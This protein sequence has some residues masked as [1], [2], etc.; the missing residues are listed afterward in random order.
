[1]HL[2]ANTQHLQVPSHLV[3]RYLAAVMVIG[4]ALM[5]I[6]A[7]TDLPAEPFILAMVFLPLLGGAVLTAHR[8]GPGGVRQLS[9]GVLRWRIGWRNWALAV[10]VMPLTTLTVA[11][12][13]GTLTAPAEGW[14]TTG[15]DYLV[16]TFLIGTLIINLW[17]ETAWQGLVQRHLTGRFG[18]GYG[19][20]LTAVPFAVIHLPLGFVGG[21][22]L[23]EAVVASILVLVMAPP[24]RYLLGRTD[25]ATGGSLLAVGVLH[26]SFNASGSLDVLVGGW[27]HIVGVAVVAGVALLLDARRT[28]GRR[29]TIDTHLVHVDHLSMGR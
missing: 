20:I 26:A 17:E 10:V 5:A 2:D 18:L 21:A 23:R 19:A 15:I 3:R 14:L 24:F 11:A 25:H 1:M 9:S 7:V 22:T 6:P 29:M 13:T 16:A 4:T 12:A 27:Q 28:A 8:S